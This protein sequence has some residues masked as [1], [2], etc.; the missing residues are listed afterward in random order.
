[1]KLKVAGTALCKCLLFWRRKNH[2]QNNK[3]GNM[4][5]V[6]FVFSTFE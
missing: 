3:L 5:S 6:S 2:L 1:M 4:V